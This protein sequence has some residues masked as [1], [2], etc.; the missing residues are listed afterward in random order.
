MHFGPCTDDGAVILLEATG[1]PED[2]HRQYVRQGLNVYKDEREDVTV[3]IGSVEVLRFS[4]RGRRSALYIDTFIE[5][6][7]PTFVRIE[8]CVD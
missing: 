7:N 3:H 4:V 8:R 2:I 5:R 6:G 1:Q